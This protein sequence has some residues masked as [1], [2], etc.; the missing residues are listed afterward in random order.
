MAG[1]TV[2]HVSG[3][4]FDHLPPRSILGPFVL[5]T[6]LFFLWGFAYGLLG[7]F[8]AFETDFEYATDY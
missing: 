7:M 2:T 8:R 4:I 5:V 1:G 6:S 3:N